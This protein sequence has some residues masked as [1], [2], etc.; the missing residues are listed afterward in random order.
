M[1]ERA[2]HTLIRLVVASIVGLPGSLPI[3]QTVAI[4]CAGQGHLVE[5]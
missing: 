4:W 3:E 2:V 5:L 1:G